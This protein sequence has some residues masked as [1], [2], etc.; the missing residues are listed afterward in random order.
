MANRA[1]LKKVTKTVRGK[2]G[3]VK[4]SY[5]VKAKDAAKGVG[6][7][8]NRHKGKILGAAA[9]AGTAYLAHKRLQIDRRHAATK[10]KTHEEFQKAREAIGQAGQAR[11]QFDKNEKDL[12]KVQQGARRNQSMLRRVEAATRRA[13]RGD[14]EGASNIMNREAHKNLRKRPTSKLN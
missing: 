12:R 2:K 5:W 11:M 7:F 6:G 3:A 8:L 9:L 4:R 13:S 10:Q 14:A 1:G